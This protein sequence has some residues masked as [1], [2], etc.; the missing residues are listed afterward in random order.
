MKGESLPPATGWAGIPARIAG[1][2]GDLGSDEL[3]HAA[4]AKGV[5]ER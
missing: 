3:I 4:D 2:P 5:D 1:R